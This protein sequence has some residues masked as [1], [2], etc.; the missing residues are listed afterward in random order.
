MYVCNEK[1]KKFF[2]KKNKAR[3]SKLSEWGKDKNER[4]QQN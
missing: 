3:K 1:K 2:W 4:K